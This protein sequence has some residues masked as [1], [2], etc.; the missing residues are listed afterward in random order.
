MDVSQKG[1]K[2][3]TAQEG[4]VLK[5]YRDSAGIWTIGVGLT[6]A[7]GVIKPH[8][9]M[10]ITQGESQRL[11]RAALN[12]QYVPAVQKLLPTCL[13][14]EFDGAV[15]VVWNCGIGA[16]KWK[17]AK[18]L[19]AGN[20]HASAEWLKKTAVTAGGKRL[21]GL[22]NRRQRE[23]RLIEYG[24]YGPAAEG[25]S[26][27]P[28]VKPAGTALAEKLNKLGYDTR[29][30][31]GA[32][33]KFQAKNG[34]TVDGIAGPATRSTIQ[35]ELDGKKAASTSVAAGTGTGVGSGG[36]EATQHADWGTIAT[37][38]ASVAVAVTIIVAGLY[39]VYRFRG[40]LFA[41]LPESVKDFFQFKVGITIGRRVSD[42]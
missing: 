35:R 9:G 32:I 41:W 21:Q 16:T 19:A 27:T 31:T 20:A 1:I 3:L 23:A 13:Q 6:A 30:M 33:K 5:A 17:W 4:E 39:L 18:A 8:K 22:V 15:S 38:A 14:H 26:R 42:V 24:Q 2:F 12:K 11:L 40:P 28:Q 29:D 34:L 7:S 25:V 37:N 36:L 10:V